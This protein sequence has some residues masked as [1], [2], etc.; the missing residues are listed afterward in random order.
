MRTSLWIGVGIVVLGAAVASCSSSERLLCLNPT[1]YC[2]GSTTPDPDRIGGPSWF[3]WNSTAEE[4]LAYYRE[5]CLTRS[6]PMPS[7]DAT[8]CALE[9]IEFQARTH[10]VQYYLPPN[11]PK[12][13][14]EQAQRQMYFENCKRDVLEPHG[15]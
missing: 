13:A 1:G 6:L 4:R 7:N 15:L 12:D 5:E 8:A 11:T 2:G 3:L 10:C 9:R 14:A